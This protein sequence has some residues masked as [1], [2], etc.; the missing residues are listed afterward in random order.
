M[1]REKGN[2]L[3]YFPRV[4]IVVFSFFIFFGLVGTWLPSFGFLPVIGSNDFSVRPWIDFLT[5]PGLSSSLKS[6]LISGLGASIAALILS[7]GIV[8]LSYGNRVW[9]LFEK[10]LAPVLSI[11]HAGFAI[12][13][14]FLISPSGWILR[15]ISPGL[16]GFVNPPDLT[17]IKDSYGISLMVCM[18]LKETPFLLLMIM[19][20]LSQI[21]IKR[22]LATGRSFGYHKFQI[23]FKVIVPQFFPNIRLSFYAVIAYSLSV[24]DL[25]MIL[26]PT[27][28]P[29]LSVLILQW[30]SDPDIEMRLTG[31]AGAC[32]LLIIVAVIIMLFFLLEKAVVVAL[33]KKA[34]DGKRESIFCK[35]TKLSDLTLLSFLFVTIMSITILIIWSFT[36]RWSFPAVLPESWSVLFWQRSLLKVQDPMMVSLWTALVSTITAIILTIGCLEYELTIPEEKLKKD[37]AKLIWFLYLPLLIPQI[38]FIFGVQI[39]L[40]I[41]GMDGLWGTL[42]LSHLIFVLPYVFLTLSSIYRNFDIRYVNTGA[43]LCGSYFKAFIFIKLPMLLRP[44]LFASAVGF[45]VSIAQYIPTIF[46]GAGRFATITTEAVNMAGG[47]DRRVLS[48]YALYQLL[49][50]MIMYLLAISIPVFVFRNRKGMS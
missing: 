48:V 42:V 18:I 44:I 16:S 5:Y 37:L 17:I 31:A 14:A 34:V 30:F 46:I 26:G 6:T 49:L 29:T 47:S 27:A 21:D 10:S 24:V 20:S 36:W 15:F 28:P 8:S 40:T 9:S 3:R 11:P 13:F 32:A 38:A 23:W 39:I 35:I 33:N 12:G 2:K 7:I 1:I 43:I 41:M 22:T 50:P 19:G 45:S 4:M 25:S